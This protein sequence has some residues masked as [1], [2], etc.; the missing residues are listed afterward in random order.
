MDLTD[1]ELQ[2]KAKS[3]PSE[4]AIGDWKRILSPDA[5]R[6]TRLKVGTEP[7]FSSDLVKVNDAGIFC[8][9]NCEGKLFDS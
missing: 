4:L 7:A 6:I 1:E 8:C 2:E 5:F 3:S 9:V